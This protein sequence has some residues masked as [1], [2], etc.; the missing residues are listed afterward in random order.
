MFHES[1]IAIS[2][3]SR[4]LQ[5]RFP[6]FHCGRS[7]LATQVSYVEIYNEHV[8]DLLGHTTGDVQVY[9][10]T[11]GVVSWE[12]SHVQPVRSELEALEC[13][14]LVRSAVQRS[15]MEMGRDYDVGPMLIAKRSGSLGDDWRAAT[16][17]GMAIVGLIL[18]HA[19]ARSQLGGFHSF[20]YSAS[21]W[22][23]VGVVAAEWTERSALFPE[24]SFQLGSLG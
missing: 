11:S 24:A 12:G 21:G 17:C 15:C 1:A 5:A 14:F 22:A 3:V 20:A 2:E 6:R 19:A 13:F 10:H 23:A 16:I 9:E 4:C 7:P 18:Y 8:F